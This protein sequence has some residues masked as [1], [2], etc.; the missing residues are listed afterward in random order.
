MT[1]TEGARLMASI[2]EVNPSARLTFDNNKAD[3]TKI[4]YDEKFNSV[5]LR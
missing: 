3:V 2:A 1:I 5:N 4:V